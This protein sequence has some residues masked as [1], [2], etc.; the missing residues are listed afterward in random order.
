LLWRITLFWVVEPVD[1]TPEPSEEEREAILAALA[2]AD[3][4]KQ[5]AVSD[6][7]EALLPARNG[8]DGAPYPD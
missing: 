5:P 8:E 3:A 1:I 6:W 2:A 4:A 7:A